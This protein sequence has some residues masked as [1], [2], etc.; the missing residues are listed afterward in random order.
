MTSKSQEYQRMAKR[1]RRAVF[2]VVSGRVAIGECIQKIN[3][4]VK[5]RLGSAQA[6]KT[7]RAK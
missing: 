1:D 7:R 2:S 5:A 6:P 3:R 4:W